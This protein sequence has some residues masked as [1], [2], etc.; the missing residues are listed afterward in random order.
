VTSDWTGELSLTRETAVIFSELR[1][2]A[3]EV[4]AF[5]LESTDGVILE[6]GS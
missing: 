1:Q 3:G 6:G 5:A 4:R 2:A